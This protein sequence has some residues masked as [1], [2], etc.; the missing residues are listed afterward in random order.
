M[1][2]KLSYKTIVHKG[3]ES[4]DELMYLLRIEMS[5]YHPN[6]IYYIP[7]MHNKTKSQKEHY[8]KLVQFLIDQ[9]VLF[10]LVEVDINREYNY[11]LQA[12]LQLSV[13]YTK[14]RLNPWKIK[15][16]PFSNAPMAVMALDIQRTRQGLLSLSL[17]STM[18]IFLTKFTAVHRII[19]P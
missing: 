13:F 4:I 15:D 19:T 9:N 8:D 12:Y 11:E 6:K 14:M 2:L 18:N 7:H 10:H 3:L 17:I 1:G 5:S 16:I